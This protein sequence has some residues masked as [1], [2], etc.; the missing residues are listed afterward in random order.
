[1]RILVVTTKSPYPLN[2]GR[3]LRTYNLIKQAALTHEV[4]L[5]SFV[6]T[7]EEIEG[8]KHMS[9]LC[10]VVESVE[11]YLNHRGLR[12]LVDAVRE[13]FTSAPIQIVKYRN[14]QMRKVLAGLLRQHRYDVVHLDMLHL[15]EYSD[16]FE[17]LP[18]V[19]MEHNVESMIIERRAHT[20]KNAI[21]RGYLRYQLTKLRRF[22]AQACAKAS[23]VVAVSEPDG[24]ILAKMSGRPIVV[25][26][27]GVDTS[28]FQCA[29]VEVNADQLVYVG[30]LTWFPNED[31]IGH[32]AQ[33]ILR[34]RQ[35]AAYGAAHR[36]WQESRFGSAARTG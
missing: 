17:G 15:A 19:L 11:L 22:E 31:A 34:N 1:M 21:K 35:A 33:E 28:Y 7:P 29:P 9:T 4:H 6:Q 16:L 12:T 26:P 2:E 13:L 14:A 30:G 5:A 18:V 25:V 3:A 24:E 8:I 36:D 27:N 32:F 10:P 23:E 20:E